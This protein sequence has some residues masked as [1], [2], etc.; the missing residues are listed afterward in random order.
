VSANPIPS[1]IHDPMAA[2]FVPQQARIQCSRCLSSVLVSIVHNPLPESG[3]ID[4]ARPH[5]V[6]QLTWL[7]WTVHETDGELWAECRYHDA[8]ALAAAKVVEAEFDV[9][10]F[11]MI[12]NTLEI[13]CAACGDTFSV[14]V[15]RHPGEVVAVAGEHFNLC[16]KLELAWADSRFNLAPR[17]AGA[18]S[19]FE[20]IGR[21][22]EG[23]KP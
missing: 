11:D 17:R 21:R 19:T 1:F 14:A 3:K 6:E 10:A 13:G 5:I 2:S 12:A 9:R 7:G 16:Q 8:A 23:P 18:I 22:L 15:Q 4:D 20:M